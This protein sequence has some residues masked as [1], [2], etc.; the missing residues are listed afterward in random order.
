M[1][2][3]GLGRAGAM[4]SLAAFIARAQ[5]NLLAVCGIDAG[6]ALAIATRFALQ[7]AYRGGQ[8]IFWKPD[9]QTVYVRDT[10]L[11]FSA[12]R[13]FERRGLVRVDLRMNGTVVH[14]IATQ[15]GRERDQRIR[16]VRYVRALLRDTTGPC[17][18]FCVSP[19]SRIGFTDLGFRRAGCAGVDGEALLARGFAIESA[20]DER[21]TRGIGTPHVA[22]L[23]LA[24]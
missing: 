5:P 23:R 10:Y 6:D 21:A 11:P 14:A 17:I 22:D 7:W 1:R 8:A 9:Y 4:R 18:F 19:P 16:E 2:A 20:G 15:I 13:P 12:L 24:G 3:Y